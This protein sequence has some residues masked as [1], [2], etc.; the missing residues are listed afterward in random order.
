MEIPCGDDVGASGAVIC[1]NV[2]DGRVHLL[3][4]AKPC[5]VIANSRNGCHKHAALTTTD[6]YS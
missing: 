1:E 3:L 4:Q 5:P 6:S 2:V